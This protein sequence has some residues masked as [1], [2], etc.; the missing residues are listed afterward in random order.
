MFVLGCVTV[1]PLAVFVGSRGVS[2]A[3]VVVRAVVVLGVVVLGVDVAGAFAGTS[4]NC[5]CAVVSRF[6]SARSRPSADVSRLSAL[7][8][9]CFELSV[10]H[11]PSVTAAPSASGAMK[12]PIYFAIAPPSFCECDL[13]GFEISNCRKYN[14]LVLAYWAVKGKRYA[15]G[16]ITRAA[17]P[18]L[19]PL[20]TE[21][22]VRAGLGSR[23]LRPR[24]RGASVSEAGARRNTRWGRAP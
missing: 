16:K 8:V 13:F 11:A 14:D 21:C 20:P 17:A 23:L 6:A 3:G 22:C 18:V 12:R 15:R 4:F 7:A 1:F 9:S 2:R 10:L 24:E 5:G 19:P